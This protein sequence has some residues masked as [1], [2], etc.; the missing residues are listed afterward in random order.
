MLNCTVMCLP[1]GLGI[2]VGLRV[3]STG[4]LAVSSRGTSPPKPPSPQRALEFRPPLPPVAESS[5]HPGFRSDEPP[6]PPRSAKTPIPSQDARSRVSAAA[7]HSTLE[8]ASGYRGLEPVQR[9]TRD[10]ASRTLDFDSAATAMGSSGVDPPLIPKVHSA[11]PVDPLEVVLSGIAQLQGVISDM[12]SSPKDGSRQEVIKPGVMKLPELPQAGPE[13]CLLFSDWLH[14]SKPALSDISDTSEEL[15]TAVLSEAGT[16]YARFLT[17]DPI[18]RLTSRPV[19]SEVVS[20]H[21]WMRVSRRIETMI[22][23]ACPTNIIGKKLA[24]QE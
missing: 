4:V 2:K 20:Q 15:W 13:S 11:K 21:K 22:L 17:L 7:G 18:A 3:G 10:H 19:P 5:G 1:P 16:W 24:L 8:G 9:E 12:A 14:A 6:E 23:A